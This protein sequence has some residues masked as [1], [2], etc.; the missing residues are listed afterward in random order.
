MKENLLR[1]AEKIQEY[2]EENRA[3]SSSK[4]N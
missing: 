1:I 2:A 3:G 4:K